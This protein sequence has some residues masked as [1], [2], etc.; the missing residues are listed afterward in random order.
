MIIINSLEELE[1]YKT[2]EIYN[3]DDEF[4]YTTYTFQN[5]NQLQNVEFNI[6]INLSYEEQYQKSFND[7][8]FTQYCF[9]AKNIKFNFGCVMY[10]VVATNLESK[11]ICD[12]N[13]LEIKENIKSDKLSAEYISA[14]N[15]ETNSL[16]VAKEFD[17]QHIKAK[18]FIFNNL[19]FFNIDCDIQKQK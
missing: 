11:I 12:I 15:I 14:K 19:N 17:C 13:Q 2:K 18:K 8:N 9:I 1:K 4:Y 10:K 3:L 6:P 16:I 5:N 7:E